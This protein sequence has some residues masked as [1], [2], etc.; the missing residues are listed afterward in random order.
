MDTFIVQASI[1]KIGVWVK[2]RIRF[3][4]RPTNFPFP[5]DPP[6]PPPAGNTLNGLSGKRNVMENVYVVLPGPLR[7]PYDDHNIFIVLATGFNF[8]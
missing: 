4:L 6:P 2:E 5:P 7:L 1:I 3:P 8:I